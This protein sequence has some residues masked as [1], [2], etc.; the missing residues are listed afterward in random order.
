MGNGN[1]RQSYPPPLSLPHTTQ[2]WVYMQCRE[3][4]DWLTGGR[5]EDNQ[6]FTGGA[7]EG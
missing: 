6:G 2:D 1:K 7:D 4:D 3:H 5:Q